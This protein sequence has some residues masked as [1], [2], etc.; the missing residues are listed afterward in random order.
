[1]LGGCPKKKQDPWNKNLR[2][3]PE[4]EGGTVAG[5]R[6]SSV[7]GKEQKKR[8]GLEVLRGLGAVS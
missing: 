6:C 8:I 3:V 5:H 2:G 1:M 4:E 7:K